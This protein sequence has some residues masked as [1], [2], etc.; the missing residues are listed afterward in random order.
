MIKKIKNIINSNYE[1]MLMS[2]IL[3]ISILSFFQNLSSI[4]TTAILIL[5]CF[6]ISTK[7]ICFEKKKIQLK[8]NKEINKIAS[9]IG[10][11]IDISI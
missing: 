5:I 8:I 1:A 10:E 11:K 4:F 9:D 6:I 7:Y 3:L 2:L